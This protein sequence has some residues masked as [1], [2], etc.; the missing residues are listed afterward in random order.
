MSACPGSLRC[1]TKT[2]MASR[3]RRYISISEAARQAGCS[4]RQMRRRLQE[5]DRNGKLLV[6]QS[7][8]RRSKFL[9]D[10]KELRRTEYSWL[11]WIDGDLDEAR[12]YE[13]VTH[14]V[15][16][17]TEHFFGAITKIVKRIEKIEKHL[18]LA[19]PNLGRRG[20]K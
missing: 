1:L 17:R 7:A 8:A 14:A 5:I 2:P 10:V 3:T 15:R 19:A 6:R 4:S 20:T 16:T 12:V 11:E 13:I 9:V 18:G